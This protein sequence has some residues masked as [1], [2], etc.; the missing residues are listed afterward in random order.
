MAEKK[1]PEF[2]I[3]AR[4]GDP[5]QPPTYHKRYTA[6]VSALNA[7]AAIENLRS[8]LT[9]AETRIVQELRVIP[10]SKMQTGSLK[11]A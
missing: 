7:E 10:V 5:A 9:V 8:S 4:L 6:H 1:L 11:P 2:V 3:Y